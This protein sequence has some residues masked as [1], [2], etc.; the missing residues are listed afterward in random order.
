MV[1]VGWN[2]PIADFN[3]W[4]QSQ[5]AL[6]A[7]SILASG[8]SLAY[9]VPVLGPDWSIPFEFPTYQA[10]VAGL[11]WLTPITLESS[12]RLISLA[13]FYLTLVGAGVLLRRV[14]RVGP[15]LPFVLALPLLAPTYISWS[16]AFSI[17]STALALGVWFLVAFH[18]WLARP[19]PLAG[20]C[21]AFLGALAGVTKATTFAGCLAATLPIA[22]LLRRSGTAPALSH[23]RGFAIT[24]VV[25]YL[26]PVAATFLWTGYSDGIKASQPLTATLTSEALRI[27]NYGT[28]DQRLSVETWRRFELFAGNLFINRINIL[29]ALLCVALFPRWRWALLVLAGLFIT[30][31]LVFT[32]L[33]FAHDYYWYA[34]G[35]FIVLA[36]GLAFAPLVSDPRVPLTAGVLTCVLVFYQYRNAHAS[37]YLPKQRTELS[38][39]LPLAQAINQRLATDSYCVVYGFDWDPTLAYHSKRRMIMETAVH[40]GMAL[41]EEPLASAVTRAGRTLLGGIAFVG[42]SRNNREFV[43]AQLAA[44]GMGREPVYADSFGSLYVPLQTAKTP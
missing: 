20:I 6:V 32:N 2:R 14:L 1:G 36:L 26:L 4:R 25:A 16:R 13:A 31:P 41:S 38:P 28:I 22:F 10:L 42:D 18:R 30:P 44:A 9:P 29:F 21:L 33:Y 5:T 40:H 43:E 11:S 39:A 8:P 12:G 35:L 17:E 19:A 7:E 3:P 15:E 23:L 37:W 24:C 27:W 34:N